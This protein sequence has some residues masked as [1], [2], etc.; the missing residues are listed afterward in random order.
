MNYIDLKFN[1][2]L[3]TYYLNII[4]I[5]R[6]LKIYA[7]FARFVIV[8]K[9]FFSINSIYVIAFESRREA[10]ITKSWFKK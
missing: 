10:V 1:S 7:L 9:R 5:D 6:I 2:S 4:K 8:V 3:I